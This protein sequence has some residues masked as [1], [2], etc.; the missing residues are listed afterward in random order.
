MS[1]SLTPSFGTRVSGSRLVDNYPQWFPPFNSHSNV[2]YLLLPF[3]RFFGWLGIIALNL[4]VCYQLYSP[5]PLFPMQL[6]FDDFWIDID[7]VRGRFCL[8]IYCD[9]LFHFPI[10]ILF[11]SFSC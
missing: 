11:P 6:G 8:P 1:S 5:N 3:Q 4:H 10:T 9:F 7:L 2:L